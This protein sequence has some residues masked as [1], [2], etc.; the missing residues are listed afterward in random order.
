[1]DGP[2]IVFAGAGH[3]ALIALSLL[4][5]RPITA[6]ITVISSGP[7]AIYSGMVPGW[8]E[9]LYPDRSMAI[10]LAP[11][12]AHWGVD[13]VEGII[14]GADDNAVHLAG[15]QRVGFDHLVINTGARSALPATL[16]H[17]PLLAARPISGFIEGLAPH[18]MDG[19]AFVIVGS[20][21]AGLEVAFA[22]KARRPA[23]SV[24]LVERHSKVL[25]TFPERFRQRVLLRL[26][27]KGIHLLEGVRVAAVDE[28]AVHLDD[29][30]RIESGCT[31]AFT[32]AAAPVWL[33]ATPFA[34]TDDGFIATDGHLRSVSHPNV[35][36]VGDSATDM[37]DPRPKSGVF[38]VR[39]GPLL[40]DALTALV[41]G[42]PIKPVALQKRALVLLSTGGKSAIGERN[43][44]VVEGKLVWRL[45]DHLD[46][47]FVTRFRTS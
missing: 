11:L 37:V 34:T 16:R 29:G 22:L 4:Q 32:G 41:A 26:R 14:E 1:M 38:S 12:M 24:S 25:A 21:V 31:L 30:T 36:A 42:T 20:G 2:R 8:I 23:A 45:K 46:R 18:L 44:L 5:E 17:R 39:Q 28:D 35:L 3:A 15:G 9:G 33:T 47:A 6:P 43:G 27:D 40:A 13:F 19:R 10:P 7:E